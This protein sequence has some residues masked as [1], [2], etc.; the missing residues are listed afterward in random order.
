MCHFQFIF[1]VDVFGRCS[2][3]RTSLQF[4]GFLVPVDCN[5]HISF[6]TSSD[7]FSKREFNCFSQI[8][9]HCENHRNPI[10]LFDYKINT[11]KIKLHSQSNGTNTTLVAKDK[12][13]NWTRF[14]IDLNLIISRVFKF[15]T[16]S[17]L[18]RPSD[19]IE[20]RLNNDGTFEI[21]SRQSRCCW[22]ILTNM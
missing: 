16:F 9:T 21:Y 10:I 1:D 5:N 11:K 13:T 18:E 22:P 7:I 17:I 19:H 14:S 12:L 4:S 20:I 8:I 6:F 3:G 2:V 15:R